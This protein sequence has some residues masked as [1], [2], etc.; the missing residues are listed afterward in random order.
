MNTSM[1]VTLIAGNP[2]DLNNSNNLIIYSF[3]HTASHPYKLFLV[4]AIVTLIVN[5][6]NNPDLVMR[7]LPL[8]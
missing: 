3:M 5:E 6:P 7:Y 8:F 1:N 2:S 4:I